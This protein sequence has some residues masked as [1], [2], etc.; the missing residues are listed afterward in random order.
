MRQEEELELCLNELEA[1]VSAMKAVHEKV[2]S[3]SLLY[4]TAMHC[5]HAAKLVSRL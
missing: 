2:P 3:S 5:N 1:D 4:L